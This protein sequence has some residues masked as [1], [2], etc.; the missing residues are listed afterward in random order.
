MNKS[1]DC[2]NCLIQNTC[3]DDVAFGD[4]NNEFEDVA[5]NATGGARAGQSNFSICESTIDCILATACAATDIATCYCGTFAGSACATQ[6][7]PG[8]GP[9]AQDEAD[10]VNQ[11]ATAAA[12]AVSP[13][14]GNRN[15][16]SGKADAI[17]AC[18]VL[19]GC[20][21]LCNQ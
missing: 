14:L 6:S 9:C 18:S 5:G 16:A 10:G 13:L 8:N 1:P 3:L 4:T 2:Y 21:T 15:S 17:F 19:N 7:L 12:S 20:S 11:L